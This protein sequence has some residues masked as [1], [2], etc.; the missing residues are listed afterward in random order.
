MKI[1]PQFWIT[2]L[3]QASAILTHA[4]VTY[5]GPAA[6][7]WN[8]AS[9]WSTNTVPDLNTLNVLVDNRAQESDV[10]IL[11]D[12]RVGSLE[13]MAGDSVTLPGGR[14]LDLSGPSL[15]LDGDFFA[16]GLPEGSTRGLR[17]NGPTTISG[18]GAYNI[19]TATSGG[20]LRTSA[21]LTNNTLIRGNGRLVADGAT[22]INNGTIQADL[23]DSAAGSVLSLEGGFSAGAIDN[24]NG[25][26]QAIGAGAEIRPT[27]GIG[28]RGGRLHTEDGGLIRIFGT[29]PTL[30][31]VTLDA[32]SAIF[33]EG[34]GD[35]LLGVRFT[36]PTT[37]TND[38]TITLDGFNVSNTSDLQARVDAT[39]LGNGEVIL[40]TEF[41]RINSI[42]STTLTHTSNHTIRGRGAI[43][44]VRLINEGRIIADRPESDAVLTIN[45]LSNTPNINTG[46]M[47]A[48]D[49]GRLAFG[50]QL[51]NTGG[52][53][54]ARGAASEILLKNSRI[55]G[56][57]LKTESG[58]LIRADQGAS[59]SLT[60]VILPAGTQLAV[61]GGVTFNLNGTVTNNGL[62]TTQGASFRGFS[63]E[64]ASSTVLAGTGEIVLGAASNTELFFASP[65]VEVTNGADHLIRGRGVIDA[66]VFTNNG[67]VRADRSED[68]ST[69]NFRPR[70]ITY[71]NNGTW[72][73][74]EGGTLVFTRSQGG[75]YDS[76]DGVIQARG[77]NSEVQLFNA[78]IDGGTFHTEDGGKIVCTSTGSI[79]NATIDAG[80]QFVV[81][82]GANLA[83]S[84]TITN[85]GTLT[86]APDPTTGRLTTLGL[87][88]ETAFVGSGEIV[89]DL[90][91]PSTSNA[92]ATIS[93]NS[94]PLTNGPGHTIRGRGKIDNTTRL[95]NS[96]GATV[97]AD[98]A[99]QQLVVELE[100]EEANRGLMTAINGGQL[101]FTRSGFTTGLLD[102]AGGIVRAGDGSE[103]VLT[104]DVLITGGRFE[105]EGTGVIRIIGQSGVAISDAHL[106][107]RIII[108][109]GSSLTLS[110]NITHDGNLTFEDAGGAIGI[111]GVVDISGG[112]DITLG[113]TGVR[114]GG[115]GI[116]INRDQT[117]SGVG[118]LG[119]NTS[120]ISNATGGIIHANSA[121]GSLIIDP[122]SL[123]GF[124]ND[125]IVRASNG[126][127][128]DLRGTG[129]NGSHSIGESGV[130][131]ALD[132]GSVVTSQG[133]A[134]TNLS[135]G[136]LTDGTYRAID[137]GNGASLEFGTA[138][139]TTNAA[140]IELSGTGAEFNQL[141]ALN[142][143]TG[144]LSLSNGA[145]LE[146]TGDFSQTAEGTLEIGIGGEPSET[147]L[148][149]RL[150]S[151][152]NAA[153]DGL[154]RVSFN[155][156]ETFTAAIGDAWQIISSVTRSG[157]FSDLDFV[158]EGLPENSR[159]AVNYLAD[160]VE[161]E[162]VD[163]GPGTTFE[164]FNTVI[165]Q[166]MDASPSGDPDGDGIS[167]LLE[168][169][170]GLDPVASDNAQLPQPQLVT[171]DGETFLAISFQRPT[172]EDRR[173]DL[174][175]TVQTSSDLQTWVTADVITE[176]EL[177]DQENI[178][179]VISRNR[180]SGMEPTRILRV[181]VV[182]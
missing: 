15:V 82:N 3:F 20:R 178:E 137:E 113:D 169:A 111:D 70:D 125:G 126:G 9:N 103:V 120:G 97:V 123:L 86:V 116:L 112:G 6:G 149:G 34:V 14:F 157:Q 94:F 56:G 96:A 101:R 171:Q 110:G 72:E 127:V 33:A 159:L 105:T 28:I 29:S 130:V 162:V 25:I 180:S 71:V 1:H 139:I 24:T 46:T 108:D 22:I 81:N 12:R 5:T 91:D 132:G 83:V 106:S 155:I 118:N 174:T 172:N 98:V 4:Q 142:E 39:L 124:V 75:N 27:S 53:I 73:A 64:A 66:G 38:G 59:A 19:G 154:L 175:Y 145:S 48:V 52:T 151:A 156:A 89:L 117:I 37:L 176:T 78:F 138:A 55:N 49:G 11:N 84:R 114:V 115:G 158:A 99:D 32:G 168:Y 57:T 17:V 40:D 62:I 146:T 128:I 30:T 47:E 143:N 140:N 93:G 58:G 36:E 131:E 160:G 13:V 163:S 165:P 42:D 133:G 104:S 153:L 2:C 166:G 76:T 122:S 10:R 177:T 43:Q 173:S 100:G 45:S 60:D 179:Q 152:G 102:N 79:R 31:G 167:N 63:L 141:N 77:A 54:V 8:D 121:E 148:W 88:D 18:S 92:F 107:G 74:A 134:I 87:S 65:P 182:R 80:S 90:A 136:I 35:I 16:L 61:D 41:S 119:L 51:N 26:I 85:F 21:D 67:T 170:F 109:P 135:G 181:S 68:D 95:F 23:E 7:N 144:S 44:Q 129:S 161:V 50:G 147:G 150:V 69:L 164:E